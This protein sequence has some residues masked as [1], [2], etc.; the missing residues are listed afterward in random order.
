MKWLI[1]VLIVVVGGAFLLRGIDVLCG[2][3]ESNTLTARVIHM[4]AT[5]LWGFA[6]GLGIAYLTARKP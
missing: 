2:Y 1:G 6:L 5:M 4:T 3:R